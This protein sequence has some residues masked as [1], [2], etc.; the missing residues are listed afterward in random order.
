MGCRHVRLTRDS[1]PT[2]GGG[3]EGVK[4]IVFGAPNTVDRDA[5][6]VLD[7]WTN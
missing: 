7:W 6:M 3:P 1:T 4:I 2:Q 5:G